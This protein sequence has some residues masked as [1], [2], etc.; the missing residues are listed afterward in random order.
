MVSAS[1]FKSFANCSKAWS[2]GGIILANK[3]K[4]GLPIFSTLI[5]KLSK[6]ISN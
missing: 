2:N 3:G 5:V 4:N 6:F 1:F